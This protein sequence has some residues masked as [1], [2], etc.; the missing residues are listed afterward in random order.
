MKKSHLF[1]SFKVL[2]CFL[3]CLTI[4]LLTGCPTVSM[5]HTVTFIDNEEPPFTETVYDGRTFYKSNPSSSYNYFLYWSESKS[6]LSSIRE[7]SKDTPITRDVTLYSI[8]TPRLSSLESVSNFELVIELSDKRVHPLDD[9]NYAGLEFSYST[10]GTNFTKFNF[11][12]APSYS[13]TYSNRILAYSLSSINTTLPEGDITFKV[14]NGYETFTKSCNYI[15]PENAATITFIDK[16]RTVSTKIISK[17]TVLSDSDKPS[18]SSGYYNYF[19]YWS[20]SKAS[21]ATAT[22]FDFSKPIDADKTFYAIYTPKLDKID[23][24]SSTE[25]VVN[26]WGDTGP[27]YSLDDNQYAGLIFSYSTD[28]E[29]YTE[30]NFTESPTCE[31]G[32][33]FRSFTYKFANVD[34]TIPEGNL[35]FKVTNGHETFTKSCNYISPENAATVTFIDKDSTE[36]RSIVKGTILSD[37]EKPSNP[38]KSYNYFLYWSESKATKATAT[39]FDFTQTINTDKTLYAIY[40]PQLSSFQSASSTE[41]VIKLYDTD[42]YPLED[43]NYAG[44]VFSYSTDGTNYTEFGFDNAPTYS[45]NGG[46]RYLTYDLASADISIETLLSAETYYFKVTNG[47]QTE[48]I[49]VSAPAPVTNLNV[50]V[51]DCYAKVSFTTAEGWTSYKVQVYEGSSLVA[52]KNVSSSSVS[53]SKSVEFYGL[54]NGTEYTFKV[55]T[56]DTDEYAQENATP[57]IVKKQSDW[58]VLMYMDGDNNLNDPIFLDLNEA[59]YG[60]YQIRNSDGTP[61]DTYD[62]V[63]VVAL[64]DGAATWENDD[65]T[66]GTP[67]IGKP[68]TYIYEVGT[69]SGSSTSSIRSSGCVLSSNTKNLSYTASWLV[70]EN[71]EITTSNPDTCGELN[72]GDKQT[73]ISFLNWANAH[74]SANKGIILQFSDH[75]GGPRSVRYIQTADGHTIKVGDTSGRRALCWDESSASDFLKTKDISDAL[76]AAGFT[77][78]NKASMILMDVCLGSS[79]EDAYQFKDCAEYLAASPNTIPGL[80]LNYENLI[81][82]FKT[83]NSLDDICKQIISDYRYQYHPSSGNTN[84]NNFAQQFY[85]TQYSSLSD[86]QKA[87]M[88]WI[89]DLGITTFTITDLSKIADVK[90]AIDNMCNILLSN[91]EKTIFVDENG[92]VTPT[93]TERTEN[94]VNYIGQHFANIVNVFNG[95]TGHFIND[96]MYYQGTYTWLYDIGHMVDTIQVL[97]NSTYS[98]ESNANAWSELK[99]AAAQVSSALDSAIKYSWRDS[100]IVTGLYN[101]DFYYSID[102]RDYYNHHY[103]LTICG[104]SIAT[105]GTSLAQGTAPDFYK[106]DLAFGKDSKWGDLLEYWFGK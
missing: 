22:E 98:G 36:S 80:G 70:S 6:S 54:T 14:T 32:S 72:M 18:I 13:D 2:S 3:V 53:V 43:G 84:W 40:T 35:T 65:G 64:W 60:L 47:H 23:S 77:G 93:E 15:S 45:D 8:Y 33:Y 105:N 101:Y 31:R 102:R 26:F 88:E 71:Q 61:K 5:M 95:D 4:F 38:N 17:G 27:N 30:F 52:S 19:M 94:Y 96:S 103:G 7:F 67:Q 20:E 104:A 82:S 21:K 46:Y 74:Y 28:G 106:I 55:L 78:S 37:S 34:T 48:T 89:S 83:S 91:K 44:I 1:F 56:N 25:L 63:N 66:T 87:Y 90:T 62:S 49:T 42:V 41:I 86:D 76:T 69:D 39:E 12:S 9:G 10:D 51:N 59:E 68:G 85:G 81:K 100:G 29:N 11:T 79:L 16:G 24:I 75:G 58:V 97:S 73:L 92:L 99:T 50:Q 57:T